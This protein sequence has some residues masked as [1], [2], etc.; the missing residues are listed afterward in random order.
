MLMI[1]FLINF[2]INPTKVYLNL[3]KSNNLIIHTGITLK[4][5][6]REVRFD[7]R[8]FNDNRDYMTTFETRRNISQLFPDLDRRFILKKLNLYIVKNY[9]GEHQIIVWKR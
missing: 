1:Y 6:L 7:F 8:A 3:D 4:N 5:N 9:I 2:I